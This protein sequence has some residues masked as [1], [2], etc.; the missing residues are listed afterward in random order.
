MAT[1]AT[2]TGA[3]PTLEDQ[4]LY[5]A[6]RQGREF[7]YA[8][9][10]PPGLYTLRLKFAEPK[11]EWAFERPFHLEINGRRVLTNFDLV[12]AAGGPRRAHE[13]VF[14]YLVPDGQGRLVLRFRGGFEPMQKSDQ[15]MVQAIEVLPELRPVVR[16][17]V[18]SHRP[19]IDWNSLVWDAD[20]HFAGGEV[21]H[22][23]APV[24]QASP[25][26][27][28][29]SLYQTA[30]QGRAFRYAVSVL[31]G[32]YTVHLKFAELWLPQPG[33]RPMT[34]EINGRRVREAWDPATAAGQIGM[35]ADFRTED[36]TPDAQGRITIGIQADGPEEA[37]LQ[38]I[39][40][41]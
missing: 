11:Y 31:P 24:A 10:V 22:S 38:G 1:T 18:G 13:R 21:I 27:Y 33:Q 6:G 41:E 7:T 34:I 5:Q 9:P 37:I 32:L 8:I 35:A 3:W 20:A 28:D 36:L 12:Q 39:E 29:Q 2:I 14:R 15:A 19:F 40:I 26:L 23:E 17:N 16:L 25:T 30:R 4:E